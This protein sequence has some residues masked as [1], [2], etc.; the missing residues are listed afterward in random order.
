MSK[1]ARVYWWSNGVASRFFSISWEFFKLKD[2]GSETR[3]LILSVNKLESV[4]R[5]V[6]EI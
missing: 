4:F 3:W 5:G 1:K 2:F 6:E